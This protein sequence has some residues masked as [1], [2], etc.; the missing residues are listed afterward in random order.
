MEKVSSEIATATVKKWLDYKRVPEVKR[1]SLS[2]MTD[3]LA[4]AIQDGSLSLNEDTHEWHHELVFPIENDKGE[5]TVRSLV[6][7]PRL[8]DLQ[9]DRA[10]KLVKDADFDGTLLRAK[11]ALTGA[12]L[13]VLRSLD[14]STD[15]P[16]ADAIA[17]FFA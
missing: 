12:D 17:I 2:A 7:K 1:A 15:K 16:I 4:S 10:K 13:N 5:V 9:M 11:V 6:Y 14:L 3:Q 8:N